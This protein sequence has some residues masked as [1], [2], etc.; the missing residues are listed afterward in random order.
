MHQLSS[1]AD[2][3]E[4]RALKSYDCFIIW[5]LRL[6]TLSKLY[7]ELPI[8]IFCSSSLLQAQQADK[9]YQDAD[10]QIRNALQNIDG[11]VNFIINAEKDHPNRI[12]ICRASV[13]VEGGYKP[14]P[15]NQGQ[16]NES[17]QSNPTGNTPFEAPSQ[18]ARTS[19]FGAPSQSTAVSSF[20]APS[21]LGAFGQ[22]S[23][24][25]QKPNP[26]GGVAQP[27]GAP[28]QLGSSSGFGQPSALGQ[29]PNPFGAPVFS[30][31]SPRFHHPT[32]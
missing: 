8:L 6:G 4:S 20:G 26:F 2:L 1:S 3:R 17:L 22:P 24:T 32:P 16:R 23:A 13:G 12:D 14:N 21:T 29:K 25:G 30:N 10:S 31:S 27:F 7:V 11:A 19:V 9:L 18:P 15:L 5:G 28:S